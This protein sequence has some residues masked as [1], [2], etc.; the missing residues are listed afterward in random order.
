MRPDIAAGVGVGV[1]V[2]MTV[3]GGGVEVEVGDASGDSGPVSSGLSSPAAGVSESEA[4]SVIGG[5]SSGVGVASGVAVAGSVGVIGGGV[6]DLEVGVAVVNLAMTKVGVRV[7]G[8]NA[9]SKSSDPQ[10]SRLMTNEKM[11]RLIITRFFWTTTN[12]SP[13]ILAGY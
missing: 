6:M 11:I 1:S 4:S 13:L 9:G 12:V 7:G 2:G 10:A 8:L 5:D 3:G